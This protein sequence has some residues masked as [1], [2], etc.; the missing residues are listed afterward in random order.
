MLKLTQ[1]FV[2]NG[3]FRSRIGGCVIPYGQSYQNGVSRVKIHS[4]FKISIKLKTEIVTSK[5]ENLNF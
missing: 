5:K 2:K 4:L 3:G 1:K